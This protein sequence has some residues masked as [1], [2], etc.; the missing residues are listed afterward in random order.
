MKKISRTITGFTLVELM[1]ATMILAVVLVG[2]IQLFIHCSFLSELSKNK[3]IA[4]SIAQG[5]LEDIRSTDYDSIVS[6]YTS[7]CPCSDTVDNDGDGLIDSPADA[8]CSANSTTQDTREDYECDDGVDNDGNGLIDFSGSDPGCS[9]ATDD[10]E[11][12]L[13]SVTYGA[14]TGTF[15]VT[16]LLSASGAVS[17]DASNTDIME[18]QVSVSWT[19]KGGRSSSVTVNSY[20]SQR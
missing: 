8:G 12:Y 15:T 1:S 4:M 2:L 17:I 16:E 9:S 20:M 11:G 19:N 3:T 10:D 7:S 5:K 13:P 14:C 6:T 18:A